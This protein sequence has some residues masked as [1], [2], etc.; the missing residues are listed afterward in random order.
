MEKEYFEMID[1]KFSCYQTEVVQK[2]PTSVV[3]SRYLPLNLNIRNWHEVLNN[4]KQNKTK[5][6]RNY[7]LYGSMY[8]LFT[9][10]RLKKYNGLSVVVLS[11][12]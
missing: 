10:S 4:K 5:G 8:P 12:Q 1:K 6:K 9:I 11:L 2:Y 3:H 7:L